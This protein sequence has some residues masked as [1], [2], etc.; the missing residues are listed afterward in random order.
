MLHAGRWDKGAGALRTL[1]Y[2]SAWNNRQPYV[3]LGV[4]RC[5]FNGSIFQLGGWCNITNGD[6]SRSA[7]NSGGLMYVGHGY[8]LSPDGVHLDTAGARIVANLASGFLTG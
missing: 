3:P 8:L 1:S 4:N 5:D 7:P 6:T 2:T